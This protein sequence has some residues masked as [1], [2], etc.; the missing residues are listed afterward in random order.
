MPVGEKTQPHGTNQDHEDGHPPSGLKPLCDE[1]PFTTKLTTTRKEG[2][3]HEKKNNR[4]FV[5]KTLDEGKNDS[6][7][8]LAEGEDVGDIDSALQTPRQ[9]EK[10][11]THQASQE[12]ADFYHP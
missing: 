5:V 7:S 6:S 10:N 9:Q 3:E 11:D 8:Q 12:M 2:H 1:R 4:F